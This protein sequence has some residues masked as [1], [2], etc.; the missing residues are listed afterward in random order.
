VLERVIR[1]IRRFHGDV[2]RKERLPITHPILEKLVASLS[3]PILPKGV[4]KELA[5]TLKT[6]YCLSFSGFLCCGEVTYDVFDPAFNLKRRDII[7]H[8]DNYLTID[9]PGS[10][11]DLFHKGVRITI[12]HTNLST[13]AYNHT[14]AHLACPGLPDDPL[15]FGRRKQTGPARGAFTRKIF[16]D[17]LK[18]CLTTLGIPSAGYS[19]H[20]FRRGAATW[21]RMVGLSDL[22]IQ[23][24]DRWTSDCFKLYIDT[25]PDVIIALNRCLHMDP[26]TVITT[27]MLVP[28]S[29]I[30]R[31]DDA[32]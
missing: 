30:W 7:V 1:G 21:A 10:K 14:V 28:P 15:F 3:G 23:R 24:L 4:S 16:I 27:A 2:E 5:E 13:C 17:C 19:S 26:P 22:D 29:D 32:L 8:D 31:G 11:T 9:L 12:A 20:S 6:A 18:P 25:Q